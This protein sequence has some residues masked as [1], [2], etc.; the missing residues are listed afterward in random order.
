MD[1]GS[2]LSRARQAYAD[3]DWRTAAA[4][5]DEVSPAH[6]TADDLAASADVMWHLGQLED[7][8]QLLAAACGAF[9]ADDR[10]EEAAH[11]ALHLGHFHMTRGDEPQ[12]MAWIGH[13][14]RLVDEIGECAALGWFVEVTELESNLK[15][16][17]VSAALRAARRV[18]DL[19]RRL[20][21]LELIA[22]GLNGEG[23]ALVRS[24]AVLDGLALLDEAMVAVLDGKTSLFAAG[25]LYCHTI[26]VCHDVADIR[27]MAR[28]VDLTEQWIAAVGPVIFVDAYCAVYRGR[29]HLVRG[30]WEEAE[31]VALRAAADLDA[32]R[33]KLAAEAWYVV[34]ESRRFR[35][36]HPRAADAYAKAHSQG[37]DPQPGR[38]QLQLSEGD[39]VGA[40]TSL[41]SALVAVGAD[42]LRRAPLCRAAVQVGIAAG[43]LD[44]AAA[45]ASELIETA[46][47]Y[48]TSGLQSMA[49]DARGAVLL[50]EGRIEAALPVLRDA[51]QRW[52]ELG[53]PNDAAGVCLRLAEAYRALGDEAS[54]SAELARAEEAYEQLG[55][56]RA[57]SKAPD[58]LSRRECEVLTLVADG[59]SNR[60]IAAA[61]FISDRTVARHLTNIYNKIGVASRTQATRYAIDHG[62]T[63]TQ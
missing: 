21:D 59:H 56:H 50:A 5:F 40:A 26:A 4:Y 7:N 29:L 14:G 17:D 43:R 35:G 12:A 58:G 2:S 24:G 31:R 42:P 41:R 16:G 32:S 61:L 23:R 54:A 38:A 62:L 36:D 20:D 1:E 63:A 47:K 34:G 44:E 9:E 53:A 49:A 10:L 30:E 28:W 25:T 60:E 22:M 39:A 11:A 6:L 45:A 18:Q 15:T 52:H 51:C 8:L 13:A 48:G 27:R 46:S 19:G 57:K 3:Q 33:V 55:V 37:R